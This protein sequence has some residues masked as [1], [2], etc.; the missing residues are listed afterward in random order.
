MPPFLLFVDTS[1]WYALL[2]RADQNHVAATQFVRRGTAPLMTSTY[3]F[4][5]TVTLVKRHLG[6][7]A[8]IRF[9]QQLWSEEVARLVRVSPEDEAQ[10]WSIFT[11][12]ADKGFSYT[13]CTSFAMM[14]RL[15]LDS[16]F[17]FDAHFEQYG[18]FTRLP[19]S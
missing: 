6:H 8:A 14:E 13:D 18:Q 10:A 17:A 3:V 15:H 12:Y 16:A 19:S 11:R 1:A 2:D 7:A 9:G 5:E 4:D